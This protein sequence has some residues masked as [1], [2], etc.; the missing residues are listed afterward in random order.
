MR[1]RANP[2]DFLEVLKN[3]DH[4]LMRQAALRRK[5]VDMVLGIEPAYA[6][7]GCEP[8]AAFRSDV[9]GLYFETRHALGDA[10]QASVVWAIRVDAEQPTFGGQINLSPGI[11]GESGG[12]TEST[13][14]FGNRELSKDP[15]LD[16][17]NA[18]R[19]DDPDASGRGEHELNDV[20][21]GQA[22]FETKPGYASAVK[23]KQAVG[24]AD[25]DETVLVLEDAGRGQRT[26][27][28]IIADALENVVWPRRQRQQ[29]RP[30]R[31]SL[32]S[33]G[34]QEKSGQEKGGGRLAPHEISG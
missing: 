32:R 19:G 21:A 28:E 1:R 22:L 5:Q 33:E 4:L 24:R 26:K 31:L 29:G 9:D 25:P 10:P 15:A 17:G 18:A 7:P 11:E 23:T 8:D 27:A 20:G 3:G 30:G 14:N 16:I 34:T 6:V 12:M 13:M 2:K